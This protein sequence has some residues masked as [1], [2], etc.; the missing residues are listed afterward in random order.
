MQK[1]IHIPKSIIDMARDNKLIFFIGAGFSRDFGFPDWNGLVELMLKQ[2][3]EDDP[4]YQPFLSLL[5]TKTMNALDILDNIQN[6]KRIIRDTI[7]KE[8]K[9]EN[10]KSHLL[11][12]HK[13]LLNVSSKII[14]T[15]YDQLIEKAA[16]GQ[17]E[18]VV[19]TNSHLMGRISNLDS[20]I[21]KIHG[22]HEDADK[23]ILL[24][25][26]YE[27]LYNEDNAALS[28][29]K[30]IIANNTIVFIGFSLSD[31]YVS[32]LFNYINKIYDGYQER[33]YMLTVNDEDF[34]KFNIKT[35]KLETYE[36]I[37]MFLDQ[38]NE[39]AKKKKL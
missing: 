13:K 4:K 31:P 34:T 20:F 39:E 9:Y 27:K 26:D 18:K 35:L 30:N 7:H 33:S 8:F 6:E 2:V 21:F 15:N 12:K 25:S 5:E 3:I 11:V 10:S 22:D 37:V 32:N 17:I 23:C 24:K 1:Q 29:F 36:E 38:L 16:D 19:Y 28:Q 14:T